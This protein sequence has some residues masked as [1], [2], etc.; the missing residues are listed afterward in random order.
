M[1]NRRNRYVRLRAQARMPCQRDAAEDCGCVP[2]QSR[3][4]TAKEVASGKPPS[5]SDTDSIS[6]EEAKAVGVRAMA[7]AMTRITVEMGV[8]KGAQEMFYEA[9]AVASILAVSKGWDPRDVHENLAECMEDT[10]RILGEK[11]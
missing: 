5:P 4:L 6:D 3:R 10:Q 8:G 7:M 11:E 2:C 1:E 9:I